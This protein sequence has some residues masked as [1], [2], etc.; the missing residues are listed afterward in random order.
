MGSIAHRKVL[1]RECFN[2]TRRFVY[3]VQKENGPLTVGLQEN[4]KV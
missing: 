2:S 1:L 3:W 4:Y